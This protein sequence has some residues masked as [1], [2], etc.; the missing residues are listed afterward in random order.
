M[1]AGTLL[2]RW[3]AAGAPLFHV[4]HLSRTPGSPLN[5]EGGHVAHMKDLAPAPGE[6]VIDKRVNAAFIGT[7]LATRLGDIGCRDILLAGLTTPHCVSTTARMGANL[8]FSVTIA[9]DACAAFAGNA[10]ATWRDG[11][12]IDP[13][14]IHNAALDQLNGEFAHVLPSGACTP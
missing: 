9:H 13:E 2:T 4:R 5:P 11:G 8:G 3:R 6:P 10:N 7:D 14:A 1:R 12:P